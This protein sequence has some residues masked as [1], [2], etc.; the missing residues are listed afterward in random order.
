[1]YDYRLSGTEIAV[2][3]GV[4]IYVFVNMV[5]KYLN[6]NILKLLYD[7]SV[8]ELQHLQG[9]KLQELIKYINL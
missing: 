2:Y 4:K 1:M 5:C 7:R 8:D 6:S 3:G 9:W